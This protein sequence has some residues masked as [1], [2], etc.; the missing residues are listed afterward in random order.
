VPPLIVSAPIPAA[1]VKKKARPSLTAVLPVTAQLPRT[2]AR[3]RVNCTC[4]APATLLEPA[5]RW[6]PSANVRVAPAWTV[7]LPVLAPPPEREGLPVRTPT[8][9]LL[10]RGRKRNSLA[11]VPADLRSV[12]ALLKAVS[13]KGLARSD[14]SVRMSNTAPS[15]LLTTAVV[16]MLRLPPVQAAS[17]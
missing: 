11:P 2:K 7:E 12:P 9:P 4:P 5:S 17:P 16:E 13:V 14:P 8:A 15:R 1:A 3:P 10:F 6:T